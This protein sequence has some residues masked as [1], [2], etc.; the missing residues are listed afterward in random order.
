MASPTAP[1]GQGQSSTVDVPRHAHKAARAVRAAR[2]AS[3]LRKVC[4]K[5]GEERANHSQQVL[6]R[7]PTSGL[8]RPIS[9]VC[10]PMTNAQVLLE[11]VDARGAADVALPHVENVFEAHTLQVSGVDRLELVSY[12]S[13]LLAP[14][15]DARS[16]REVDWLPVRCPRE[17]RRCRQR[18]ESWPLARNFPRLTWIEAQDRSCPDL[19]QAQAP[20]P[21][22]P[23]RPA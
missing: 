9:T 8:E 22:R 4:G 14:T 19:R 5:H 2:Q 3:E 13:R 10:E 12:A 7:D 17:Q 1:M 18:F 21:A 15:L 20:R 11:R 16:W 6:W 23:S